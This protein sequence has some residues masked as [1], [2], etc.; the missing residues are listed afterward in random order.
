MNELRD[1]VAIVTGAS[2]PHGI[3]RAI[4]RRFAQAGASL[5]L[6]ADQTMDQLEDAVHECEA[7]K[8]G[9][10]FIP[11]LF[12]LGKAGQPEAMIERADK[13]FGR[14]D[15][16]INNAGIRAPFDFG[17]FS[18]DVFDRMISVNVAAAFFASQAV[19][20][21]MRRQG[22]GRI[23]HVSSQLGQVAAH[24]QTLYGL[25]KAALIHL[26]KS[27]A[28]ELCTENI[29]VNCLSPGPIATDP[30][31]DR[32]LRSMRDLYAD[33][34]A[35]T[36]EADL[37]G[38][39]TWNADKADKLPIGRLGTPEEIADVALYLAATSP[40][41]LLGQDIVVDGGYLNY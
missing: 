31:R 1:K 7:F 8:A 9:G 16:L 22:G 23:V 2:T 3:G 19:L 38:L 15:V 35:V 40:A 21:V 27:M 11:A 4:A 13:E 33:T 24:Q 5:L 32:G 34:S 36:A 28:G 10:K 14:I 37:Q 17:D 30:L 39:P 12:D 26:T 41:F 6:V 25:T 29:V 18:R 20:P